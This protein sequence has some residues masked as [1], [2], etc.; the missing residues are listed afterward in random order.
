MMAKRVN[1]LLEQ[2]MMDALGVPVADMD[3]TAVDVT[4]QK[5]I[6]GS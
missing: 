2:S 5:K 3:A 6:E 4:D 1:K